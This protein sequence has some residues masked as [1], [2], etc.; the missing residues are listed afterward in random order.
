[1]PR[2]MLCE[3]W[4]VFWHTIDACVKAQLSG[5]VSTSLYVHLKQLYYLKGSAEREHFLH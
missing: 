3:V 4:H 1:M 5:A 2:R